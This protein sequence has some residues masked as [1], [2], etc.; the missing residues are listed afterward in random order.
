MRHRSLEEK[1][2]QPGAPQSCPKPSRLEG[3]LTETS[4]ARGVSELLRKSKFPV[5]LARRGMPSAKPHKQ[6]SF[7]GTNWTYRTGPAF[8]SVD[9]CKC[10]IPF[11]FPKSSTISLRGLMARGIE[12]SRKLQK[13]AEEMIPGGVSSPVRA[14][15]AVG[16]E[17]PFIVRGKGPHLWDADGNQ[18]I[19]YWVRG[20]R[21]ILGHAAKC[22]GGHRRCGE[23]WNQFRGIHRAGGGSRRTGGFGIPSHSESTI[24]QLGDRSDHVGDSSGARIYETQVHCEIRRVLP[25][26]RG[27]LAG[28]G[29]IGHCHFGDPRI[30]GASG[31]SLSSRWRCHSTTP[32]LLS[33]HSI[34]SNTRLH[35]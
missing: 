6:K 19:D 29:R 8:P 11:A 7:L 28:E 22:G 4:V 5:N 17:Q 12:Q 27:R 16:G 14:F 20:A 30:G 33:T 9:E 24:C 32:R 15:G 2:G 3:C 13:R 26:P 21:L 34:N 31:G 25:R 23:K 1:K 10:Y 35:A 18:Y